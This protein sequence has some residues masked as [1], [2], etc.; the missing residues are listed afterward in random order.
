MEHSFGGVYAVWR[1]REAGYSVHLFE[2]SHR[3]GGVWTHNRYPGARVDTEFPMYQL[4]IPEVY[5][6]WNWK[7]RFPDWRELQAYFDHVDR[8]LNISKDATYKALVEKATFDP[9]TSRWTVKTQ[10]GHT[11]TCKQLILCTGT[12]YKQH[13]PTFKGLELY[14][15]TLLH[16]SQW[17]EGGVNV[18]GKR[19]GVIGSGSTAL[20]IVQDMSKECKELVTLVRTPNTALPMKQYP[21]SDA[22]QEALKGYYYHMLRTQARNSYGGFAYNPAPAF[23]PQQLS[24][25]ER[26]KFL[27]ELYERGAF[28]FAAGNFQ[29]AMFDKTDNRILYDFWAKKTRARI[30]D[31]AKRDILAP[32]E[33]VEW[34][35]TKRPGVEDDYYECCDSPH[36]RVVDLKSQPLHSF[37]PTGLRIGANEADSEEI[38]L[39]VVV[40]ATGFDS[41]H[42]AFSSMG[43][44]GTDD[45]EL[46][47]RWRDGVRTHLGLT[48]PH[49]PNM[50]LVYGPQAPTALGNGP[51]MV[52][53]QVDII[54]DFLNKLKAEDKK[55]IEATDEAAEAWADDLQELA[56][57]TL[58]W[59]ANSWYMGANIPGKKREMLNYLKGIPEY[60]KSCRGSLE[61]GFE[62]FVVA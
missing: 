54:V 10:Q 42:G 49:H 45:R 29:S 17:P 36:V 28:N 15:G 12:T 34:W 4:S 46:I 41:Y 43:I 11:A 39:D 55:T 14:K 58:M 47:A 24:E 52:E 13:V 21:I 7:L 60:E 31:P 61:R 56:K 8:V 6:S 5:K 2:G 9:S 30:S 59:G 62:G 33:P 57:Q 38:Q 48:V 20:Q 22:H 3:L 23:S 25:A 19:V 26:E 16:S 1:L 51:T 32:L 27:E 40:L 44:V 50:W 18:Q 53:M 35:L 37:T